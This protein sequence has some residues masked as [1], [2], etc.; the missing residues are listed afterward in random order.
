MNHPDILIASVILDVCLVSYQ[1]LLS[2]LS[3]MYVP[4]NK[5]TQTFTYT[6]NKTSNDDRV[7]SK[8]VKRI[9]LLLKSTVAILMLSITPVVI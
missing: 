6:C 4:I 9:E 5:Q 2:A 1:L 8:I 7:L 3:L